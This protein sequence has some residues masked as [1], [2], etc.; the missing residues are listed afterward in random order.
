MTKELLIF[1]AGGAL[2][3]GMTSVMVKKDYDKIY[4]F[5][6]HN[7]EKKFAD[8]SIKNIRVKDLSIEENTAE[9]F[10]H[11]T[12]GKDKLFF[13][14]STIG[15]YIGGKSIIELDLEEWE[16]MFRMNLTS[17]FLIAKYFSRLVKGS[18]GGSICF[19][20]AAAALHPE[21]NR[22]AY[23]ASKSALIN[24]VETLAQEGKSIKLSANAVAPFIID[25]PANREWLKDK[26]FVKAVKP[27][28]IGE[29]AH[30]L[31]TYY[32]FVSG[33]VITLEI[34]FEGVN[35]T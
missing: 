12:A 22:A 11:L 19:T 9:A 31:F 26:E 29:L 33:N 23:S 7:S 21:A 24:L 15:G 13:L 6:F 2:G 16:R 18:A 5:D 8:L 30:S 35:L 32:N 17:N 25:T 4:L 34:R 3:R 10:S 27:E 20:S 28:E 14:F 1:G